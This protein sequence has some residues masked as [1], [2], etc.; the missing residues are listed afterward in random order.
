M[1]RGP[2]IREQLLEATETLE[3]IAQDAMLPATVIGISANTLRVASNETQMIIAKDKKASFS[4][5]DQILIHH[6]QKAYIRHNE[7]KPKGTKIF[8]VQDLHEGDCVIEIN[9]EKRLVPAIPED[10]RIG[11]KVT[12]DATLSVVMNILPRAKKAFTAAETG[13]HWDDIG[14]NHAA[15]EALIEAIE[16]PIKFAE[17]YAHYGASPAGGILLSGPAGCGKTMLAKAAATSIGSI[18]GFLHCKGPEVLDPY[19]GV[20]EATVR[21]LFARAREYQQ[22]TSRRA[23][24]FIDEAEAILGHR[25]A[26]YA[27]ME[28]TIVPTFLSE[29]DGMDESPATVIL[30]TNRPGDLDSAVVRDGRMDRRIEIER[31]NQPDSVEIVMS[32]LKKAPTATEDRED[33]ALSLVDEAFMS[34][35][36]NGGQERPLA[37]R[38]SVV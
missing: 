9:G 17:L 3:R 30:A 13:V 28:K 38:K 29:M 32:H 15:K 36:V 19:V 24:I 21:G 37:D 35:F 1:S 27:M 22:R 26:R 12:L 31:P 25:G 8:V 11:D 4:I 33:L 7:F 14:G 23:V 6:Q 34:T 5:G 16:H 2:D 18:D 10:V 20:A